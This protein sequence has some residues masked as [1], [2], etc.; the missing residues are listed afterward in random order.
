MAM[1]L[2][3]HFITSALILSSYTVGAASVDFTLATGFPF[4]AVV[5]GSMPS[6]N[7]NRRWFANYKV[8]FNDG[9]SAGVEQVVGQG[10][11][12]AVG[13]VVGALGLKSKKRA[14]HNSGETNG[15]LASGVGE[16]VGQVF[17]AIGSAFNYET[18]DGLGLSYSYHFNGLNNSGWRIRLEGGYGK[19]SSS[20]KK[21]SDGSVMISYQF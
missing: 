2:L 6:D 15:D 13:V 10:N 3:K 5:E 17:C 16:V 7:N 21:R 12:H 8:G 4:V 9:F 14:C 20:D 18:T 1:K 11:T 19:G